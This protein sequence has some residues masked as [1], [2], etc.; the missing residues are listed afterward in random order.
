MTDIFTNWNGL[1][2]EAKMRAYAT[3]SMSSDDLCAEYTRAKA[4]A[5]PYTFGLRQHA[6]CF[7]RYNRM[8]DFFRTQNYMRDT[9]VLAKLQ[10]KFA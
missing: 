10:E 8:S 5:K 2:T 3:I 9:G 7:A 6:E 4:A 1:D